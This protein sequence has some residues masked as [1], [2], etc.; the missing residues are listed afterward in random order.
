M[1]KLRMN[2]INGLP[3][4]PMMWKDEKSFRWKHAFGPADENSTEKYEF[5]PLIWIFGFIFLIDF[6]AV[7]FCLWQPPFWI[8]YAVWFVIKSV[9]LQCVISEPI[10]FK[11]YELAWL[12]KQKAAI[13][14][15]TKTYE[16][17]CEIYDMNSPEGRDNEL[18]EKIYFRNKIAMVISFIINVAITYLF[19]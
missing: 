6:I 10:S 15:K 3:E 2:Q 13:D 5:E 14:F 4:D 19:I 7:K 18:Q 1:A 8:F 17:L 9:A 11:F 16:E 12:R